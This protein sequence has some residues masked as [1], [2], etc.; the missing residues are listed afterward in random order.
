MTNASQP[1]P[2]KH[3]SASLIFAGSIFCAC[4]PCVVFLLL[5]GDMD[6]SSQQD[7]ATVGLTLL[8]GV[9]IGCINAYVGLRWRVYGL[10]I[11][12]VTLFI[13]AVCYLWATPL[14]GIL[15]TVFQKL[16]SFL[17]MSDKYPWQETSS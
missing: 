9:V 5:L 14:F 2:M 1:L 6:A 17:V 10:V 16:V 13:S 12:I 8:A 11:W 7:I 15:L 3:L 4:L